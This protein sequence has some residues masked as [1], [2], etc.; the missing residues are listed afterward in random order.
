MV[1]PEALVLSDDWRS[2]RAKL[3]AKEK[4]RKDQT[5]AMTKSSFERFFLP[6]AE[7]D[8]EEPKDA[9]GMMS[10]PTNW[11]H[12]L[13]H[14]EHGS[15]LIA[16]E[17][18]GGVFSQAVVLMLQVGKGGSTGVVINRPL[19]GTLKD[20]AKGSNVASQIQSAFASSTVTYGG[21][22]K[23]EDL[24]ILHSNPYAEGSQEVIPGVYVG[25]SE[26]LRKVSWRHAYCSSHRCH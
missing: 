11:A 17:K 3:V 1:D 23:E 10:L 20:A 26:G 22:V 15:V 21:P 12:P 4:W 14:V 16:N 9:N 13:H 25:G 5:E 19:D 6:P 2:F 7:L 8:G 18:L 24:A